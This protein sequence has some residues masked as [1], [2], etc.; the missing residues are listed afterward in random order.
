MTLA[1]AGFAAHEAER[2]RN[3]GDRLRFVGILAMVAGAV[4]SAVLVLNTDLV[5]ALLAITAAEA[6]TL[7]VLGREA[8]GGG[9]T[10]RT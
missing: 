8:T 9:A 6:L 2:T 4:I 10:V 1:I 3:W 5:W 7:L